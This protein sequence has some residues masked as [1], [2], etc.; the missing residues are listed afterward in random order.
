VVLG[1]VFCLA[2]SSEQQVADLQLRVI[3]LTVR[4]SKYL[5]ITV[6]R[7]RPTSVQRPPTL[8][9]DFDVL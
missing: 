7:V 3:V 4:Y 5:A 2:S 1:G 9:V 8:E 6:A